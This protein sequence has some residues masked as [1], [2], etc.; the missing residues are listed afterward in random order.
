[1]SLGDFIEGRHRSFAARELLGLA[2]AVRSGRSAE[3][4]QAAP[5]RFRGSGWIVLL[6]EGRNL[7][8]VQSLRE[9]IEFGYG[10]GLMLLRERGHV[11]L[12]VIEVLRLRLEGHDVFVDALCRDVRL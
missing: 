12:P 1:M 11:S 9:R 7:L 6:V 3:R 10:E 5:F 2:I 4:C 8:R